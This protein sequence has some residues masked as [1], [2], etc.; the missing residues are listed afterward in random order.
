MSLE[1]GLKKTRLILLQDYFLLL[2]GLGDP[3]LT[4]DV[5][6]SWSPPES[7]TV[8]SSIGKI[9]FSP[10]IGVNT[11]FAVS[12]SARISDASICS[13]SSLSA[14]KMSPF[15][16]PP[17]VQRTSKVIFL[18]RRWDRIDAVAIDF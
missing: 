6:R 17:R 3:G 11:S 14:T 9:N 12:L 7:L 5:L 1:V 4:W 15:Q 10:F 2:P 18:A 13:N 16:I 8:P